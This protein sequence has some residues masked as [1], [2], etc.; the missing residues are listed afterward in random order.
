MAE[1]T[2]ESKDINTENEETEQNSGEQNQRPGLPKQESL[3]L[4]TQAALRGGKMGKGTGRQ[5]RRPRTVLL[6]QISESTSNS[7]QQHDILRQQSQGSIPGKE[8]VPKT[9]SLPHQD[10]APPNIVI[11][12]EDCDGD[13]EQEEDDCPLTPLPV[14]PVVPP[15][16]DSDSDDNAESSLLPEFL[17][18][19]QRYRRSSLVRMDAITP[20]A[21]DDEPRRLSVHG[22][23]DLA[24]GGIK[25]LL[26]LRNAMSFDASDHE[27]IDDTVS[28]TEIHPAA[29]KNNWLSVPKEAFGRH[30]RKGSKRKR[31]SLRRMLTLAPPALDREELEERRQNRKKEKEERKKERKERKLKE[32][33]KLEAEMYDEEGVSIH[34]VVI[35][36]KGVKER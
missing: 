8:N 9:L 25:S 26:G 19:S 4:Y 17:E 10:T 18:V 14:L 29:A 22:S 15:E 2:E 12:T 11:S 36:I 28:I 16:P 24:K 35:K 3:V 20:N 30:R 21:P 1:P 34:D 5:G 7:L 13:D 33:L 23:L 6:R 32:K 27:D 31:P